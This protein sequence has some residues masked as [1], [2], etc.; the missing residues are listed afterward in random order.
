MTEIK[1]S[2]DCF[3]LLRLGDGGRYTKNDSAVILRQEATMNFRQGCNS[4]HQPRL[5][6]SP[7]TMVAE[8]RFKV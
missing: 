7:A 8:T 5:L 6:L 3:S 4:N 1:N 2:I